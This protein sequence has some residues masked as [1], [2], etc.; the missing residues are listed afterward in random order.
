MKITDR[1]TVTNED[2]MEL[3]KYFDLAIATVA[4]HSYICICEKVTNCK[5]AKLANTLFVPT[6]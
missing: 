2:C 5:L 3:M 1:L 4:I 6:L